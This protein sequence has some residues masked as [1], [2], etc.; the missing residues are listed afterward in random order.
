MYDCLFTAV[1]FACSVAITIDA[2]WCVSCKLQ[3]LVNSVVDDKTGMSLE[4]VV[5]TAGMLF[6]IGA[7]MLNL[8]AILIVILV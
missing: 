4:I 2:V 6:R 7:R 8:G 5:S 1:G 3:V